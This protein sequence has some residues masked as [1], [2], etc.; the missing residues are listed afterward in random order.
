MT[1]GA[2]CAFGAEQE[3]TLTSFHGSATYD[4]RTLSQV[5]VAKYG[6][7][8]KAEREVSIEC[9]RGS[10][11]YI[12]LPIELLKSD[13]TF[14]ELGRSFL[15]G[16][17]ENDPRNQGLFLVREKLHDTNIRIQFQSKIFNEKLLTQLY[18]DGASSIR[19]ISQSPG[20]RN[21]VYKIFVTDPSVKKRIA[22]VAFLCP[23]FD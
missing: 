1:T 6:T 18:K 8:E 20:N 5:F 7:A 2:G 19:M 13:L 3:V 17:D 11:P 15:Q 21:D 4:G 16:D 10:E 9:N 12:R 14:G 22:D 23:T